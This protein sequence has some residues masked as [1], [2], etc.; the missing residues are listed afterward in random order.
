MKS[1]LIAWIL[2]HRMELSTL[3]AHGLF[4]QM[5]GTARWLKARTAAGVPIGRVAARFNA[6]S[7]PFERCDPVTGCVR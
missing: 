4:L 5:H 3:L 6:F 2:I 1:K 7:C